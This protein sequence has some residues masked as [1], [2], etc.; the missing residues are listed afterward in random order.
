MKSSY[1]KNNYAEVLQAIVYA[2]RPQSF[3]V[4][5]L[6]VLD[7]YSTLAIAQG[8]R[9]NH[10]RLGI[11]GILEAYD[12]FDDYEFT[13]GAKDEVQKLLTDFGL[14]KYVTLYK[15]DAFHVHERYN[16]NS[17]CFLHVDLDN[18]GEKVRKI[19]ELWNPKMVVGGIIL[20]EGGTE[21]RDRENWMLKYNKAPI[22]PEIETNPIIAAQYI[23]ATYLKWPGLTF[24]LKK[25]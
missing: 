19:L 10:Q 20:I 5:E 8:L 12:L 6:G 11:P 3:A 14:D 9:E 4:V 2:W 16:D 25:R 22:K 23:Y 1:A 7:G 15:A 13:H 21:E 24:L 18:T 17:V